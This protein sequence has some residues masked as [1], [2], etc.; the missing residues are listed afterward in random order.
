MCGS[1][2]FDRPLPTGILAGIELQLYDAEFDRKRNVPVSI[3]QNGGFKTLI[4]QIVL[5]EFISHML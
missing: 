5:S 4:V 3:G 2:I 1:S